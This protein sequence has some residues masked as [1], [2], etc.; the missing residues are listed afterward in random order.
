MHMVKIENI[1]I[2][3]N[4]LNFGPLIILLVLKL[5]VRVEI[6]FKYE[7]VKE[8]CSRKYYKENDKERNA[9]VQK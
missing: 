1:I 4:L 2:T 6:G 3:S 5:E 7:P 9:N 8:E